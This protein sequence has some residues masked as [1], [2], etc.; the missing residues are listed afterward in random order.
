M[1]L[2]NQFQK[3]T[4]TLS[5]LTSIDL[6]RNNLNGA[7]PVELTNLH[8][9]IV[10]NLSGNQ[11]SGQIPENISS[12]HQ[13]AS[14]DLSSNILSGVI[15]SSMGSMSFLSY[16]NFSNNNLSGM[17]PYKGQMTTFTVSAFEGNPHLCGAP[18]VVQCQNGNSDNRTVLENDNSD[19]FPDKWFYVSVGLGF[20]TGILVPYY[21]LLVRKP[22]RRAYFSFLD[23]IIDRLVP[24]RSNRTTSTKRSDTCTRYGKRSVQ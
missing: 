20:I 3:Y 24:V 17:V 15:P 4:K 21:I 2:K 22:W 13:L 12:L 23:T 10:L 5:L 1:N 6:S 8:G 7:F 9:L 19:E 18:L 16:I 11:I 14:L